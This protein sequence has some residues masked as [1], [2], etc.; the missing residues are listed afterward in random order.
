[1]FS[2]F[3]S[4]ISGG[5]SIVPLLN[6]FMAMRKFISRFTPGRTNPDDLEAI[7]VQRKALLD[8]AVERVRLSATT[9]NKHYLLFIGPR[10]SG[11]TH[12]LTL[13]SHRLNSIPELK[14]ALRM[15]WLNEDETSTSLLD[16]CFRFYR[17]LEERYPTEFPASERESLLDEPP[18]EAKKKIEQ[19]LVRLM[20]H[21][22]LLIMIENL[23][24]LFDTLGT[25]DQRD[26]R[27]LIQNH[28]LFVIVGTAQRLF[29]GVSNR[30]APFF[31]FFQ[32]EYLK[33]LTFDEA[34]A[35]LR[36]IAR[37]NG[38]TDLETFLTTTKGRSRVRALHRISGG[39][40]RVYII[41]S[42]FITKE[43]LDQLVQ[44]FEELVDDLTPYYQE[45]IRSL[46]PLQRKI[47]EFLCGIEGTV[48][49][50]EIARNLFSTHQTISSQ[51]KALRE[52]GYVEGRKDGRESRYEL[53]EPLMRLCVE[54][55]GTK[56]DQ[57]L[58]LI[59]DFLRIWYDTEGLE[60]H[61]AKLP[62]SAIE[63]AYIHSALIQLRSEPIHPRI[64]FLLSDLEICRNSREQSD[65]FSD[66]LAECTTLESEKKFPQLIESISRALAST[67]CAPSQ[68]FRMIMLRASAFS[69]TQ[70]FTEAME[71]LRQVIES[72]HAEGE[73]LTSALFKRASLLCT[74][75]KPKE[76]IEE[77]TR[78]IDH[79]N[80]GS[81]RQLSL[82]LVSRANML[83]LLEQ[84]AKAIED[85]NRV[86]D[87][88]D[89]P[90]ITLMLALVIRGNAM[91][92][93][94]RD[95]EAITDCS[96][97]IDMKDV[98][99]DQL[100]LALL[101]RATTFRHLGRSEEALVDYT[102]LGDLDDIPKEQR[103]LALENR[104]RLL[105]Q[106]GR[107]EEA[108][109]AN[110]KIIS[111]ND[112]PTEQLAIALIRRGSALGKLGRREEAIADFSQ[113]IEL[114]DVPVEH[115][116]FALLNRGMLLCQS[117]RDDDEIQN[118]T[119]VIELADASAHQ[120]A[121]ALFLRAASFGTLGRSEE[122]IRDYK[123]LTEL[124]SAP[125]DLISEA[126]SG[127]TDELL[128]QGKWDEAFMKLELAFATCQERETRFSFWAAVY[129]PIIARA[130]GRQ[131]VWTKVVPS[132]VKIFEKHGALSQLGAGLV[133][134]LSDLRNSFLNEEG[135][136][137]W[138]QI[139][140]ET[141]PDRPELLIPFRIFSTG[142][143]YIINSDE[144]ILLQLSR[145]E[146]E[147]LREALQLDT[148]KQ[149]DE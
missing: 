146:R 148:P 6:S 19:L 39:N 117:G 125:L 49:V 85:C 134:S 86:I 2:R 67:S 145:E 50:K 141:A 51:L 29:E 116:S 143:T 45:R 108:I 115:L 106:L 79:N 102:R 107:N 73:I 97:V 69:S 11:K 13:L 103:L 137:S 147:V 55:K 10:G 119:R 112:V 41:L 46:A 82:A 44:P 60:G 32:T 91:R 59:V 96:R 109:T 118:Y 113:V 105:Y 139:W 8:E 89:V 26:L 110:Y 70:N 22:T 144:A 90:V 48:P 9:K 98:P 17:A 84:N 104:A 7:F 53:A 12:L 94:G 54:V 129:L 61:L 47:V 5:Y 31:G 126:W 76:A 149:S 130:T 136:N 99:T 95:E 135:L 3:R 38:D 25:E 14:E 62:T 78:I 1:M 128:T 35:L 77:F 100:G 83:T 16:L 34:A 124:K 58:R 52:M 131:G 24:V 23:D 127:W 120:V 42:E 57:P 33:F 40:H 15:A 74:L 142:I 101:T 27:A 111:Q 133:K 65:L 37:L 121:M 140:K 123:R 132:L 28:P 63:R 88:K 18:E 87:R 68:R 92:Q 66:F 21:R 72:E 80:D 138:K 81:I 64:Q 20:G 114:R 43:S 56:K 93:L 4:L 36:N 30:A 71:D 75:A 122:A